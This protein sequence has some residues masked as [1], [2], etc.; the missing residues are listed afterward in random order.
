MQKQLHIGSIVSVIDEDLQGKVISISGDTILIV[1]ADG[2]EWSYA[3]NELVA[4]KKLA[5]TDKDIEKKEKTTSVENKNKQLIKL[6]DI[7]S[8]LDEG[9]KG[10]VIEI[11]KNLITLEESNG[12]KSNF[13]MDSL[14]VYDSL[15][16][17]DN[18]SIPKANTLEKFKKT[19]KIVKSSIVD[20]H[21]TNPYLAKNKILENQLKIFK[22][23]LNFALKNKQTEIIFI[24][25]K[26]EGILKNEIENILKKEKIPYKKAP[27]RTFGQGAI[28]VSLLDVN[29][30]VR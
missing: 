3:R 16:S 4:Y 24:H 8:V 27:H 26:G 25:G 19:P 12:F 23:E 29:W 14:I 5:L 13:H 15:L 21:N 7:V 1:D 22:D 6:G 10:Q 9:I 18:T 30:I 11:N 17:K 28:Q 2:F 20:L